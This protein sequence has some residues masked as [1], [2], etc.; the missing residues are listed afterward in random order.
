MSRFVPA[1]GF[2]P[3]ISI[4]EE[5]TSPET[6]ETRGFGRGN[7]VSIGDIQRNI[8][9]SKKQSLFVAF[10]SEE[11]DGYDMSLLATP[12]KYDDIAYSELKPPTKARKTTTNKSRKLNIRKTK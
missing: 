11:E 7:I 5:K 6:L 1:G 2:P 8:A 9:K 3:I 10:G 12:H 4:D